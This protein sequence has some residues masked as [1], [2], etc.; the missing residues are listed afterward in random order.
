[1][2]NKY[3]RLFTIDDVLTLMAAADGPVNKTFGQIIE[4]FEGKFPQDEPVFLLRAQDKRALGAIRFYRE[5]QRFDAD[6]DHLMGVEQAVRD[7]E[8]FRHHHP[9]R[10]KEPD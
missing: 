4:G 8:N 3:G 7:F 10:L 1:V 9:D 5:R 2:D 6:H